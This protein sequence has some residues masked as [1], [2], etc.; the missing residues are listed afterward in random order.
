MKAEIAL[1]APV[2]EPPAFGHMLRRLRDSRGVSRERLAFNAGV[3]SSYITHLEKG[4]R[5]HPTD[6]VVDAFL[7]YLDRI[8]RISGADRRQ[9]RDLA[10]LP[11]TASP[12]IT[13]LRAAITPDMRRTLELNTA[14]AVVALGGNLLLRNAGW[15]HAF[16]GMTE[17][18]NEFRWLFSH[19]MARRVLVDW[20]QECALSVHAFRLAMGGPNAEPFVDLLDEMLTYPIFRRNWADAQVAEISPAWRI[21]LRDSRTGEPRSAL[22]QTGQL[23][24]GAHP[25]WLI[26][27]FLL[28][29]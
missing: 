1:D 5:T 13:E 4:S 23:F 22:V 9:L 11:A 14:A 3:S 16:P 21:R 10:G 17:S 26:S 6:Q 20:E 29:V 12:T 27:Q 7:R 2:S 18:G 19:E 15:E 24:S 28:P 8:E 25:G